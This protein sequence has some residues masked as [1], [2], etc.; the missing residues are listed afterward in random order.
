[1]AHRLAWLYMTG[2]WPEQFIDHANMN[3]GDN[4][5][6]NLR[7]ANKSQNNANQPART[8]SGLKGAYWSNAS[9]S[10]QAK[11]N[12]RYLGSYGTAEEA[13]AAYMEA[14]RERFG[15]FARAA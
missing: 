13:H 11:I 4:R 6:G 9:M 2:K 8:T 14:A 7:E 12:K 1:M 15:E 10:W 3:K 5:W